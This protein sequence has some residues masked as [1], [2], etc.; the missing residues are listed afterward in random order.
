MDAGFCP[1]CGT[2][3]DTK[4]KVEYRM[5]W[6]DDLFGDV[7]D[8][9]DR[10][11]TYRGYS[12]ELD[13]WL[14]MPNTHIQGGTGIDSQENEVEMDLPE[15]SKHEDWIILKDALIARGIRFEEKFGIVNYWI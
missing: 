6:M 15:P 12:N 2:T 4:K 10:F 11:Y 5:Q 1:A 3:I 7:F 8:D 14:V 13:F 9:N